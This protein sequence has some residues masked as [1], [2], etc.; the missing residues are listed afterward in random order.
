[1]PEVSR[2]YGIVIYIFYDEHNPPHLHAEYAGYKALITFKGGV[3]RGHMPKRA[4]KM[5]FEWME[6][7]NDQLIEDWELS[8]KGEPLK[9][10]E[11]LE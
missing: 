7:H 3:V 4:L 5:V 11:P 8:L 9:S 6:I 1:M 2:F 10:I